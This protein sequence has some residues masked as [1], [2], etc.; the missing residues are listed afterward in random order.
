MANLAVRRDALRGPGLA[1]RWSLLLLAAVWAV[2]FKTGSFEFVHFDDLDYLLRDSPVRQGLSRST[3]AW[4]FTEPVLFNWH[5]LTMLSYL[6]D[7][8]LWGMSPGAF[9]LVNAAL[10]AA[11][12]VVL[13]LLL[14]RWTAHP[15]RSAIVAALFALHPLHVESVAWV[16]ERK[17]VLST[18]F[19]LLSLASYTAWV[20][21]PNPWRYARTLLLYALG[22]MS[23]PML[24]TLPFV[25]L[26]LDH[27]PLARFAPAGAG[28]RA[29]LA[30]LARLALE[31]APLFALALAAS[32]VALAT[33]GGA[34]KSLARLSLAERAANA[35]VS[36]LRYLAA[37]VWPSELSLLYP[38]PP[39]VDLA[40][41]AAAGLVLLAASAAVLRLARSLPH[42]FT[43]WFWYVGTLVPVIGLVQVG[44][45][46]H[47]DR[48]TYI[49]LIGIFF[50]IVWTVADLVERR[51]GTR[52]AAGAATAVVL[53][54]FSA[55]TWFQLE[56]WRNSETLLEH[57]ITVA[58][59]SPQL[60]YNLATLLAEH[61]RHAEAVAH[62]REV[63]RLAPDLMDGW[64]QLALT[65]AAQGDLEEA[66]RTL[67]QVPSRAV[68]SALVRHARGLVAFLRG[69]LATAEA[70][71]IAA[72]RI[73]PDFA[74]ARD[75]LRR[76]Y[77]ERKRRASAP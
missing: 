12:T 31:K 23:K 57:A 2:Y 60:Q 26:L 18:L 30:R 5:P 73:D 4:A 1:V 8:E 44:A 41:G 69:D 13:F 38:M 46:S 33:Q 45:Q 58:P 22:L 28:A 6:I 37:M 76:V 20:A 53:T 3:L 71:A 11:N 59:E 7:A 56:H 9:H 24:V 67:A 52:I 25:L 36:Y 72:L 74:R 29:Q 43:G 16:S 19:F 17:D 40:G 14:E 10:H 61:G 48:Y 70:E 55:L 66:W 54:L 34:M 39:V 27:W 32:A 47:A 51:R 50:A 21:R 15:A 42:L 77:A 49:P 35:A 62:Y 75:L 64:S 68:D 65:L 63:V